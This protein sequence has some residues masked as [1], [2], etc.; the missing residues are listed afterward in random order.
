MPSTKAKTDEP[1]TS[2]KVW[3][4][5][6]ETDRRSKE[7]DRLIKETD[8]LI[9]ENALEFKEIARRFRETDR[10]FKETDLQLLRDIQHH[11]KRLEIL[12]EYHNN[13]PNDKRKIRGAIAGAVFY[14]VVKNAALEAGLYVLQQSGDTMKLKA[15]D[16][17][18]LRQW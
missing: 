3:A 7:T 18:K 5:F 17:A 6:R 12:R 1:L 13:N 4:M 2:E 8:R 11:I 14:E 9:K 15:P 10:R 16:D